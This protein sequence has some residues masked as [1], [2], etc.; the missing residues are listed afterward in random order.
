[1]LSFVWI[2]IS[3]KLIHGP[4]DPLPHDFAFD[5]A[6]NEE[7]I[8]TLRRDDRGILAVPLDEQTG[9]TPDVDVDDRQNFSAASIANA[10]P[11]DKMSGPIAMSPDII[12]VRAAA[13]V[14]LDDV[15]RIADHASANSWD[16]LCRTQHPT[17]ADHGYRYHQ[18]GNSHTTPSRV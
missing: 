2:P 11:A 12:M 9:G 13:T 17:E 6:G 14:D 1:M 8:G 15:R 5:I 4:D 16:G 18:R 7:F 10:M 3:L